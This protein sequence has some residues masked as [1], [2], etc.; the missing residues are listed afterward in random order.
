MGTV[1]HPGCHPFAAPWH[2]GNLFA[3]TQAKTLLCMILRRLGHSSWGKWLG[4]WHQLEYTP[5]SRPI[6]L[7]DQHLGITRL[8]DNCRDQTSFQADCSDMTSACF[9]KYYLRSVA[10]KPVARLE[11]FCCT[12]DGGAWN[13]KGP[14][15][16]ILAIMGTVSRMVQHGQGRI[17]YRPNL[18]SCSDWA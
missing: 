13:I 7:E 8:W 11:G 4:R 1:D 2:S 12:W 15:D 17:D 18:L 6:F 9:R 14:A 3:I 16:W 5:I 10:E